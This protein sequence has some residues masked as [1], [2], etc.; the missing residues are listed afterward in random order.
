MYNTDSLTTN[1]AEEEPTSAQ[2]R[3]EE[4]QAAQEEAQAEA[5]AAAQAAAQAE[6]Q[7]A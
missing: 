7:E 1:R 3:A 4:A 2:A 5:Q 6:A